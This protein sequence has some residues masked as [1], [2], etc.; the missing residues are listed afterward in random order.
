[1]AT[2]SDISLDFEDQLTPD[3]DS[4]KSRVL[5]ATKMIASTEAT[6]LQGYMQRKRPWTDRTGEAK[7]RLSATVTSPNDH[8]VRIVLAHGVDYG[9]WLELAN[10]GKYAIIKP[11]IK[12][13]G[14]GVY[15][16]FHSFLDELKK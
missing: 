12:K 6:K 9:K 8:L 10:E 16:A 3:L 4:M 13:Q 7:R 1:M 14:P 11:T 5:V 2:S 15:K